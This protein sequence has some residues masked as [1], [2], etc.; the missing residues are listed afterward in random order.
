MAPPSDSARQ[1]RRSFREVVT[2]G[3]PALA[4]LI[5]GFVIAYQFVEP[6]PPAG[7]EIATGGRA[8]AYN[9]FAT[10][11]RD[12]VIKE[13]V[14]F[15]V[16]ETTG[17][18]ENLGLLEDAASGIALALVQ[19]GTGDAARSP[20]LMSLASLYYEPIWVFHRGRRSFRRLADLRGMRVAI[21][22]KGSGTRVVAGLL[23][24]DNGMTDAVTTLPLGGRVAAEAL[25]AGRIDAAFI[26]ASPKADVVRALLRT[27]DISVLSFERAEAYT[28]RHRFLSR[29][30]L[31]AGVIDFAADMPRT[32]IS[33]LASTATLVA[34]NDLHPALVELLLRAATRV[35]REGGLFEALGEFPSEKNLD[36][37]ISAEARRYIGEGPGLLQRYLPF[38]VGNFLD[39]TKVMLLPLLTL[40]IPLFRILSPTYRWRVRSKIIRCYKDLSQLERALAAHDAGRA[41][42]AIVAELDRIETGV[43]TCTCHPA[44]STACTRSASTSTWSAPRSCASKPHRR[45]AGRQTRWKNNPTVA[46]ERRPQCSTSSTKSTSRIRWR[47]GTRRG[48]RTS[49]ISTPTRTSWCWAARCWARTGRRGPAAC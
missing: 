39:R 37:P 30:R 35:H 22:P 2:V 41:P 45:P 7:I 14:N 16:R 4:I 10:R 17:S 27:A 38:W 46:M 19:G 6:A 49:P 25:R 13:G 29:V 28:R 26:V 32:D 18:L 15:V 42:T 47:S 23:L 33:L 48:T 31:P 21:G 3:G 11:Y 20:G 8:G 34:R 1:G 24:G 40:L 12:I 5:A 43:K 9:A 36:F 44:I